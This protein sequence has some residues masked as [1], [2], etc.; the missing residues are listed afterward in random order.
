M[1]IETKG[2]NFKTTNNLS[3]GNE[4]E[5]FNPTALRKTKLVYN[6]GLSECNRI[7]TQTLMHIFKR[8]S[9]YVKVYAL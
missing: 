4:S 9:G 1:Q 5:K 2:I 8:W 7:K 3:H 6:F